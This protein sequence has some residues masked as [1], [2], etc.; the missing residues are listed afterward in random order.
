V[1]FCIIVTYVELHIFQS[2]QILSHHDALFEITTCCII[3]F[4][5][6]VPIIFY[7]T[8]ACSFPL[9]FHTG[10]LSQC[11]HFFS[12]QRFTHCFPHFRL[13]EVKDERH[14]E[15]FLNSVSLASEDAQPLEERVAA[16]DK[17][18]NSNTRGK[19]KYGPGGSREISF[20]S[21]S[22]RRYK[23]EVSGD[24]EPKDFKRRGVQSLGLK[25][26]KAEYY[27]F[28]GNRGRGRGGRGRGGRGGRGRGRGR[29]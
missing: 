11:L 27:M 19:V 13:Y 9:H 21:K 12:H 23:E 14:A 24:D 25:Q 26:G 7:F 4:R 8:S 17:Q 28:G 20:H 10:H 6:F 1:R 2:F 3:I 29:R 15:A 16:L 22:S 18:Q 5:A